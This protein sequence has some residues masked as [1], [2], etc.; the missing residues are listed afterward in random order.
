MWL[1]GGYLSVV[2]VGGAAVVLVL[3]V[4]DPAIGEAMQF[5][6]LLGLASVVGAGVCLGTGPLHGDSRILAV[7]LALP[8]GVT[9]I[10]LLLTG[11]EYFHY[12]LP[13]IAPGQE[14]F[15]LDIIRVIAEIIPIFPV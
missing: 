2:V 7:G 1:Y 15:A 13:G 6:A 8:A 10:F 12:R 5:H 4:I 3:A 9:T 11:V 14:P